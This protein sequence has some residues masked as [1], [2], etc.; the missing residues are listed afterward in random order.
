M[1]FEINV[2]KD[3]LHYFATHERSITTLPKLEEVVKDFSEKF[4][5]TEGYSIIVT[6]QQVVGEGIPVNEII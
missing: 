4:P 1:W 3:G 2:S 5:E 6:K